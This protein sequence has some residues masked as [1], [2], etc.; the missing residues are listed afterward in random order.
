MASK[1]DREMVI[2]LSEQV[3]LSPIPCA[4]CG[5]KLLAYIAD[6]DAHR[7]V[8]LAPKQGWRC[9]ACGGTVGLHPR[10]FD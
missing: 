2:A 6:S 10:P 1:E 5:K 3:G 7:V 9:V 8:E 4:G